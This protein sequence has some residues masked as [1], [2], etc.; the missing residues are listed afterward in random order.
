MVLCV[1]KGFACNDKVQDV[2]Q[3]LASNS[4]L[5]ARSKVTAP[6]A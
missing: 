1:G 5:P 2:V 4:L 3:L 6:R